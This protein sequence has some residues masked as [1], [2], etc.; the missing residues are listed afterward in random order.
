MQGRGAL[1]RSTREVIGYYIQATDGQIGHVEDFVIDTATWHIR[2]MVVDTRNWWPGKKVLV[3]PRWIEG[4][5]WD[6]QQVTVGLSR[7][8]IKDS[9][10]FDPSV[11]LD[12]AYEARLFD[13]YSQPTYWGTD[14]PA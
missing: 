11:P 4:V 10:E 2:Y 5:Q 7:D 14:D 6:T 1:L 12:R 8:H 9:P 13:H 3:S